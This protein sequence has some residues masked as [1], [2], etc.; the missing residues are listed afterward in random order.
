MYV[1]RHAWP[2]PERIK[3]ADWRIRNLVWHSSFALPEKAPKGW[4]NAALAEQKPLAGGLGIPNFRTELMAM[5][6][7]TVGEWALSEKHMVHIAGEILQSHGLHKAEHVMPAENKPKLGK[8]EDLWAT[9]RPWTELHFSNTTATG[10][11][12]SSDAQGVRRKLRHN[13]GLSTTWQTD[14]LVCKFRAL[15]LGPMTVITNKRHEVRGD[16]RYSAFGRVPL[17]TIELWDG[18]GQ[19]REWGDYRLVLTDAKHKQV[20]DILDVRCT[21]KGEV[22]QDTPCR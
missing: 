20:K 15:A 12:N 22:V 10:G 5:S 11:S 1:A 2:L 13:N 7:S 17:A 9:G 4:I 3:E 6:A 21:S 19:R 18:H 8:R 14:G 16:F